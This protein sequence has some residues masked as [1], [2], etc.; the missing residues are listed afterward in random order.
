MDRNHTKRFQKRG[1]RAKRVVER[2]A[3]ALVEQNVETYVREK[4]KPEL[5]Q[6]ARAATAGF[7]RERGR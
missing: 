6:N 4:M 3:L 2:E 1:P 7:R 5:L